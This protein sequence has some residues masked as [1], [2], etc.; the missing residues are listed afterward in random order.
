MGETRGD[1][2]PPTLLLCLHFLTFERELK[3]NKDNNNNN[4]KK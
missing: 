4:K 3:L 2:Q 1:R